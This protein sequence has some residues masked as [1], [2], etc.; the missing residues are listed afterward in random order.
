MRRDV[1]YGPREMMAY[2]EFPGDDTA[3]LVIFWHGG[4]WKTGH[5]GM[6]R[7]VGRS[8]QRMGAHAFV[9]DYPKY[10]EQTF[11]G[12]LEDARLAAAQIVE[13]HPG[14]RVVLMG[15]SSGAHTALLVSMKG[16]VEADA[17]VALAAPCTLSERYWRPVFGDAIRRGLHDP[18]TFA[19]AAPDKLSLLLIHGQRDKVVSVR[20][21]ISLQEKLVAFGKNSRLMTIPSL[22]HM[23]ILPFSVFGWLPHVRRAL[24][25]II[26]G[27]EQ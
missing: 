21:S 13:R 26:F 8:L 4:S 24:A 9:V 16:L 5:K 20:D 17:V 23:L 27:Q 18:R 2:D 7:F 10:P 1:S 25:E 14:R 15:H 6:Y 22:G 3:P 19:E 12:F 11:P